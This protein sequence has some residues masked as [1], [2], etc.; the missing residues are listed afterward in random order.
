MRTARLSVGVRAKFRRGVQMF[1]A[2]RR[3]RI[4]VWSCDARPAGQPASWLGAVRGRDQV[5]AVELHRARG[6][7]VLA[8]GLVRSFESRWACGEVGDSVGRP[9]NWAQARRAAEAPP[10]PR[11][12]NP[13][14]ERH[15]G[16]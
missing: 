14:E 10:T 12:F 5:A 4:P 9:Q 7:G 13:E 3:V 2:R 15:V 6:Q 16:P 11:I 1:V 8:R